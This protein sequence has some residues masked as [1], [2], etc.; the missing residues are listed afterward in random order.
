MLVTM[1][2][3]LQKAK[4]D[5]YGVIACTIFDEGNMR[6]A[7][8]AAEEKH[9]PLIMNFNLST[10]FLQNDTDAKL[11][12]DIARRRASM[13]KVPVAINA[14]HCRNFESIMKA[15]NLGFTSVMIDASTM[16]FEDNILTT[17]R[18]VEVAHSCGLSVEAELGCVGI[19]N[20]NDP[21]VMKSMGNKPIDNIYTDPAKV[22]EFVERTNVD[23]LAISIG[24]AHGPY[25]KGITPH[26]EFELLNQIVHATD[27]PLVLHGGSGTGDENLSKA[28]KMGICKINVATDLMIA[29]IN[30]FEETSTGSFSRFRF[31]EAL[32]AYK[33]EVERYMDVFGSTNRVN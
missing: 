33:R 29:Q 13:A 14:D 21:E 8:E 12:I 2:E 11:Y 28:C 17:S 1:N 30:R 32:D 24:N 22:K 19:A 3:I 15:I 18:V 5:A 16:P 20:S 10:R 6:V 23:C 27:V 9:S 25:A 26:I 4:K 31:E 7:I